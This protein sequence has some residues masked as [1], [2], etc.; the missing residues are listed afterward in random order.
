L[1]AGIAWHEAEQVYDREYHGD[2]AGVV[3][4][5]ARVL[6]PERPEN[7]QTRP[8]L[9]TRA[10]TLIAYGKIDD[11][12][13]D[14]ERALAGLR[15]AG[16]DAQTA[17]WIL[18]VASRC[19]HAAGREDEADALLAEAL[20]TTPQELNINL[21]LY[22]VELGRGNEYLEVT[23]EM[24]GHVW[25][26]AG[27]AAAA[28]DLVGAS[29]IYGKVGARFAEAWAGLLAAER[30]DTSRLDAALAY[31]E[32]QRATPYVQRCRALMQA[33]A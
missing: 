23:A 1:T 16:P 27:R 3:D 5:A 11:A 14:A 15:E 7:Y 10:S 8:V 21:P 9:A 22:L 30:G 12:V 26:K 31:F 13:A 17:A 25:L 2:L 29:K 19:L 4:A 20:T 24:R 6:A 28:E 18:T 33:S 32:E